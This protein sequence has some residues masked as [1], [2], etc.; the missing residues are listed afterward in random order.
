MEEDLQIDTAVGITVF[1]S[2]Q[3]APTLAGAVLD[4]GE[5]ETG[6]AFSIFNPNSLFAS[7]GAPSHGG[8]SCGKSSCSSS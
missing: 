3:A 8:C 5:T 1:V 2:E 7:A 4:Y 6:L